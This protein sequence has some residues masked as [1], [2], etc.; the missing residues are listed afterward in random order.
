MPDTSELRRSAARA[1]PLAHRGRAAAPQAPDPEADD[2]ARRRA[3]RWQAQRPFDAPGWF[4]RRLAAD[5]LDPAELALLLGESPTALAA[6]LGPQ[7][8][9]DRLADAFDRAPAP[10]AAPRTATSTP[11]PSSP[12]R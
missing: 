11:S 4:D 9:A 8:W 3:A 12:P 6:R 10:A 2:R 5:G 1:V 7:G